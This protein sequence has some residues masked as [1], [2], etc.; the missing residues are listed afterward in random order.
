[1]DSKSFK[2]QATL[3]RLPVPKLEST[4]A[5]LK[6]GVPAVA[7]SQ[8]E[9]DAFVKK[10]EAFEKSDLAKTLQ[11]RLED[12]AADPNQLNWIAEWWDQ[13]AYFTYRDSV[14]LN[15]SYYCAM[16]PV[17]AADARRRLSRSSK[18]V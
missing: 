5:K 12:R 2:G 16:N 13:L 15:V 10:L 14:V 11:K 7:R 18:V 1:M 8:D 4:L 3:P 9:T 17:D 6:R